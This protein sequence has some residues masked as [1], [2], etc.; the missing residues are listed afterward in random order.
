MMF[1]TPHPRLHKEY[2]NGDWNVKF[3]CETIPVQTIHVYNNR[4]R[5]VALIKKAVGSVVHI[6]TVDCTA[7]EAYGNPNKTF[8]RTELQER[9][10]DDRIS[11]AVLNFLH[12]VAFR[13]FFSV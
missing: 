11:T 10:A 2:K 1:K 6:R 12:G 5:F 4:R 7:R 8:S 9:I 13:N 3:P